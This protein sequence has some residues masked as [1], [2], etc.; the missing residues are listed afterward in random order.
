MSNSRLLDETPLDETPVALGSK[1]RKLKRIVM[2]CVVACIAV[3]VTLAP[4]V[5]P[6][7]STMLFNPFKYP[8]GHYDQQTIGAIT[9]EEVFFDGPRGTKLSG[10]YFKVPGATKTILFHHGQGGN[11][12]HCLTWARKFVRA[13]AS[14]FIYDFEGYGRSD[15]TPTRSGI[16][17]DGEAAYKYLTEVQKV[18]TETIV[19][20]GFSLGSGV[21]SALASEHKFCGVI[22]IAPYITLKQA[23]L[24]M[25]PAL[26]IYPPVL[27]PETKLGS[28]SYVEGPHPPLLIIH[29]ERDSK[30]SIVHS[31]LLYKQAT[32]P[33]TFIRIA[34]H[35]HDDLH[36]AEIQP[37]IVSF[38]QSLK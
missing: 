12:T 29:G 24:D 2:F 23:A 31:D 34:D 3:Y 28:L 33:K 8:R 14:F 21:A 20:C 13:G 27:W 11:L 1:K 32:L 26:Q 4:A 10:W 6:L 22:L 30:I 25:I 7:Y 17:D 19:D 18:P 36:K 15:G 38:L 5:M 37:G 35:G 9:R 16:V